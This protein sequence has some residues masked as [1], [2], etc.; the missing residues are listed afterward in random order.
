MTVTQQASRFRIVSHGT[1]DWGPADVA[2]LNVPTHRPPK[3]AS[4]IVRDAGYSFESSEDVPQIPPEQDHAL[5]GLGTQFDFDHLGS[6]HTLVNGAS[7]QE[8]HFLETWLRGKRVASAERRSA[9][10]LPIDQ[11]EQIM[12]FE[13]IY[14]ELYRAGLRENLATT[15]TL[16]CQR[17]KKSRQRIFA[18]LCM[19]QLPTE[20]VKFIH[21]EI[22]D[23]DLPFLFKNNMVYRETPGAPDKVETPITLFQSSPWQPHIRESFERYQG[24]LSA[25]IFKLSWTKVDK[26]L[27]FPLKDQ[28]VLPFMHVETN[29]EDSELETLLRHYGGTSTVRRVKIHP[30]H[31]NARST[32]VGHI[33]EANCIVANV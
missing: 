24:Q 13:H 32:M 26:V 19:L 14:I 17:R 15:T 1:D 4:S 29:T 25:P 6:S 27:H 23:E 28:L 16:L 31:H 18:I 3:S 10:F 33:C 22:Y 2:L 7:D 8:P 30:A 20:I 9:P 12:T 5:K 21:T 11:L